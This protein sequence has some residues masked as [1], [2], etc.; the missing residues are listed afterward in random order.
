VNVVAS[1][2]RDLTS[3][4]NYNLGSSIA[5]KTAINTILGMQLSYGIAYDHTPAPGTVPTN[6]AI[7]AG[8]TLAWKGE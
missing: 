6:H 1:Y 2:T 8:L 7:N 4:K 5:L 3:A